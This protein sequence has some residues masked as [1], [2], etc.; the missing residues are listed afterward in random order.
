[1]GTGGERHVPDNGFGVCMG[2]M[3]VVVD[4]AFVQCKINLGLSPAIAGARAKIEI[5]VINKACR[6]RCNID[7]VFMKSLAPFCLKEKCCVDQ[8]NSPP[9]VDYTSFKPG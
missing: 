8:L 6:V 4:H 7:A 3:R 5:P 9:G 2:M 1:M